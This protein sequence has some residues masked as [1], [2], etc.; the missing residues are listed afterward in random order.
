MDEHLEKNELHRSW[1]AL[2]DA[3][4]DFNMYPARHFPIKLYISEK[5]GRIRRHSISKSDSIFYH[6]KGER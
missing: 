6:V 3:Q 5:Y 1:E 4:K 2:T